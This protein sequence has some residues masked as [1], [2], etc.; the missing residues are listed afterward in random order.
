M[1]TQ[2][3]PSGIQELSDSINN[4]INAQV[5]R[6]VRDTVKVWTA[7]DD[8]GKRDLLLTTYQTLHESNRLANEKLDRYN[9]LATRAETVLVCSSQRRQPSHNDIDDMF[10][11]ARALVAV[12]NS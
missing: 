4:L 2:F 5:E 12:H 3:D 6:R 8:T 9:S 7:L 1:S 11:I 10:D